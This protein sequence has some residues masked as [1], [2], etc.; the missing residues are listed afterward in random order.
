M[1][2]SL[3][4]P[5]AREF[6]AC[7]VK[8]SK[9]HADSPISRLLFD[10]D[11]IGQPS[12][13]PYFADCVGFLQLFYLS[14]DSLGVLKGRPPGSLHHWF[15]TWTHIQFVTCEL[16]ADPGHFVGAPREHIAVPLQ[17]G[18]KVRELLG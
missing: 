1:R 11:G 12:R 17:E 16:R 18:R 14:D 4:P 3:D 7:L 5:Y 6:D 8:V 15:H 9:V 2:S 13:V 10:D